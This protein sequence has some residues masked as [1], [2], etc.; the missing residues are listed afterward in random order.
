[1]TTTR[2]FTADDLFRFNNV[3]LDHYTETYNLNFYFQY[4]ANW[5]EYFLK[6]ETPHDSTVMGYIMGKIETA[7]Q[8]TKRAKWHGHV[9]A[10]TVGPDYRRLGLAKNMMDLLEDITDEMHKGFFVDLFVRCSNV[11]AISMYEKL[12]YKVY[13]RINRYYTD[14]DGFD[15]RKSMISRDPGKKFMIPLTRTIDCDELDSTL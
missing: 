9:T 12:G 10:L 6:T 7:P 14:E 11:V 8:D 1:M 13:R 15:M 2:R 4:L 5:P 3:N